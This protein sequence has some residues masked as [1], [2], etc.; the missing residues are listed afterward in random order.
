M[1]SRHGSDKSEFPRPEFKAPELKLWVGTSPPPPPLEFDAVSRV[2]YQVQC[3][4]SA[5]P[6][7]VGRSKAGFA[8]MYRVPSHAPPEP[9][10]PKGKFPS[11]FSGGGAVLGVTGLAAPL[12]A[13]L[14]AMGVGAW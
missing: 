5:P 14:A 9:G 13:R 11:R 7:N 3:S 6:L 12:L 2:E 10:K 4:P 8:R 1:R